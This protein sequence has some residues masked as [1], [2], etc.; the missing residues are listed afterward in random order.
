MAKKK[1]AKALFEV[2]ADDKESR[3]EVNMGVPDW[4]EKKTPQES[5]PAK[6]E[7]SLQADARLTRIQ[8]EAPRAAESDKPIVSTAGGRLTVSLNYVSCTV[9]MLAIVLLLVVAFVLGRMSVTSGQRPRKPASPARTL[10]KAEAS[11]TK[12][13]T[14][15]T[16]KPKDAVKYCLVIQVMGGRTEQ[17]L[18]DAKAIIKYCETAGYPARLAENDARDDYFVWSAEAYDSPTS[19]KAKTYVAE[20]HALGQRY[21]ADTGKNYD[22]KQLDNKGQPRFEKAQ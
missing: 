13:E 4:M 5:K 10:R 11:K 20:I 16:A 18:A 1:R 9:A 17:L 21:K 2:M 19:N 15:G 22:F 3:H 12:A 7:S 6:P 8:T 14:S